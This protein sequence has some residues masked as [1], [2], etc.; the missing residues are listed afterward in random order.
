ML[1]KGR[2]HEKSF[3]KNNGPFR[4]YTVQFLQFFCHKT[5]Q[6][7]FACSRFVICSRQ[8]RRLDIWP[9]QTFNQTLVWTTFGHLNIL[10]QRKPWQIWILDIWIFKYFTL[11]KY[12][13][14]Y[15]LWKIEHLVK[16]GS[17]QPSATG[18]LDS[19]DS[20]N[21]FTMLG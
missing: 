2:P 17:L 12:F 6:N 11:W 20:V 13:H 18:A 16:L 21:F 3:K 19:L 7:Y 5:S 15:W 8:A 4:D 1:S 10:N 9:R 14:R